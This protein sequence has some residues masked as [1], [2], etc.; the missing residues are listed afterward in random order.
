MR[1]LLPE[2][3]VDASEEVRKD[4]CDIIQ[5][6]SEYDVS[7]CG[8]YDFEFIDMNGKHAQYLMSKGD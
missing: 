8:L 5:S 1:G 6:C 2:I 7:L 4:I 3:S